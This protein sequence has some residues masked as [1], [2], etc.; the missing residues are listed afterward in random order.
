MSTFFGWGKKLQNVFS[1]TSSYVSQNDN[2]EAYS[3]SLTLRWTFSFVRALS[4][5]AQQMLTPKEIQKRLK[6]ENCVVATQE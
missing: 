4:K 1:P 6:C 2:Q 3:V 5:V